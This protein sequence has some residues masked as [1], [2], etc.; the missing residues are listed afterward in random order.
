MKNI[1]YILND[2]LNKALCQKGR[3]QQPSSNTIADFVSR[4]VVKEKLTLTDDSVFAQYVA[5]EHFRLINV[6]NGI[7]YWENETDTKTTEQLLEQ[8]KKQ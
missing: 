5:E 3:I 1:E 8:F 4:Y 6:Q 2:C 7:Y